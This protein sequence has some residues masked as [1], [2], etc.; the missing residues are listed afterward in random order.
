M[1]FWGHALERRPES[2]ARRGEKTGGER[3]ASREEKTG[4]ERNIGHATTTREVFTAEP[5]ED[6]GPAAASQN[7]R[8][9]EQ[10]RGECQ[11]PGTGAERSEGS[12]TAEQP[13]H[14][15]GRTWLHKSRASV[16][17]ARDSGADPFERK[18]VTH[19]NLSSLSERKAVGSVGGKGSRWIV[20][21]LRVSGGRSE[22]RRRG[23]ELE[24][25]QKME[26]PGA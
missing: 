21:A 22:G 8:G 7:T 15:H 25:E 4:G 5:E 6:V 2:N 26:R 11:Y 13:R 24:A 19:C 9:E 1:D 20:T 23:W 10:S 3:N 14:I 16:R 12:C 18:Y 17:P